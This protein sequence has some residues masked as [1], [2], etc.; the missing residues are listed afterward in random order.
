[1]SRN[2]CCC[3]CRR[4]KR[5]GKETYIECYCEIDGHYISYIECFEGWCK[6]WAKEQNAQKE[7]EVENEIQGFYV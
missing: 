2:R 6:H 5:I 1:M 3:N 4:N 7:S